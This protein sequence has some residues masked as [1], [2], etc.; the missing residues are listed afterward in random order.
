MQDTPSLYDQFHWSF[1]ELY[2]PLCK[3]AF[4]LTREEHACED[5]VQEIFL[6]V[7]EKRKDLIGTSKLQYY[8]FTAVRNNCYTYIEKNRKSVVTTL[9]G[10]EGI[11]ETAIPGME[12]NGRT[13]LRVLIKEA[14]DRL[15]P[16]CRE[17]FVLSRVSRFTYQ[18]IA[19]TLNISVKTVENQMI[20]ALRI[21]RGFAKEKSVLP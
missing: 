13:D 16:R 10:A 19:D 3:Y 21:V 18:Q 12:S 4:A 7:W 2:E 6:H 15:P 20:K 17:V 1:D 14:L 8:L 11:K 9:A 5:I